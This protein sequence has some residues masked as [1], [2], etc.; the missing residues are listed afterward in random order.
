MSGI[1]DFGHKF[2]GSRVRKQA[3]V[4][5]YLKNLRV[6]RNWGIYIHKGGNDSNSKSS[7]PSW[8]IN[9]LA[10]L[11]WPR[12]QSGSCPSGYCWDL[13]RHI[14]MWRRITKIEAIK[15]VEKMVLPRKRLRRKNMALASRLGSVAS[16]VRLWFR[17]PCGMEPL[18]YHK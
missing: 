4:Q 16:W 9:T 14:W 13:H 1:T 12:W 6:Y 15:N 18:K 17:Q 8:S 5:Q 10:L 3:G 7:A 2:L 11:A